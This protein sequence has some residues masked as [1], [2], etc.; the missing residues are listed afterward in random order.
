LD[1][2]TG[3]AYAVLQVLNAQL[4]ERAAW[5]LFDYVDGQIN[6]PG[7]AAKGIESMPRI[8]AGQRGW[9]YSW[10][11]WEDFALSKAP[12]RH[13]AVQITVGGLWAL[14]FDTLPK[15]YVGFLQLCN[16]RYAARVRLPTEV[17]YATVTRDEVKEALFGDRSGFDVERRLTQLC[18]LAQSENPT[19]NRIATFPDGSWTL[20]VPDTIVDYAGI[21]TVEEYVSRLIQE[22]EPPPAP[23]APEPV[24]RR[25]LR[26]IRG[27]WNRFM[28]ASRVD[29]IITGVITS[30]IVAIILALLGLLTHLI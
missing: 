21:K 19:R 12:F 25:A 23:I 5:P 14:R 8:S 22:I 1:E 4:E 13:Q 18:L 11:W 15:L 3:D 30:L 20:T 29:Q 6:P 9:S 17:V 27:L 26:R 24:P 16:E 10:V 2:A 7:S 28:G